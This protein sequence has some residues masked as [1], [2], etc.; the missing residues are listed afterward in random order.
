MNMGFLQRLT[1]WSPEIFPCQVL[2][3]THF[4]PPNVSFAPKGLHH[5][6]DPDLSL[7]RAESSWQVFDNAD[8]RMPIDKDEIRVRPHLSRVRLISDE[9]THTNPDTLFSLRKTSK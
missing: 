2:D 5:C 4:V 9:E 1:S 8:R 3:M 6:G 7:T